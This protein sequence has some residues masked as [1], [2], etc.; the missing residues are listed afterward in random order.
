M[1]VPLEWNWPQSGAVKPDDAAPSRTTSLSSS[2]TEEGP[3]I[4]FV[5]VKGSPQSLL[6]LYLAMARYHLSPWLL[7][8]FWAESWTVVTWF[9]QKRQKNKQWQ[10]PTRK[11]NMYSW[12]IQASPRNRGTWVIHIFKSVWI[13][14]VQG[15]LPNV[16]VAFLWAQ[17]CLPEGIR[18]TPNSLQSHRLSKGTGPRAHWN[19]CGGFPTLQVIMP[20][21]KFSPL[22]QPL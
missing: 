7:S 14:D 15:H 1:P 10:W 19:C 6:A 3:T 2:S 9:M 22:W 11:A 21:N 20:S 12:K 4:A 18:K 17:L 13:S 5:L 16:F 8:M